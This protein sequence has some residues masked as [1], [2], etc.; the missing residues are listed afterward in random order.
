M[1][2]SG[3]LVLNNYRNTKNADWNSS[4]GNEL[5]S[6]VSRINIF[7]GANRLKHRT[8][9]NGALP[10]TFEAVLVLKFS[11]QNCIMEIVKDLH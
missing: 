5:N 8:F 4:S 3:F 1:I 2:V 11:K 10:R 6:K 9:D 7:R